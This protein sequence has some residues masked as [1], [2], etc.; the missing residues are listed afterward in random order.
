MFYAFFLSLPLLLRRRHFDARAQQINVTIVIMPP[1]CGKMF[2]LS[3]KMAPGHVNQP[4]A[5]IKM[6][7]LQGR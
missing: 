5:M 4:C 2:P 3:E 1:N 7:P 6:A